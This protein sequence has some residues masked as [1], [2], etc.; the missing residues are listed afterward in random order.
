MEVVVQPTARQSHPSEVTHY[1]FG[2]FKTIMVTSNW[3]SV[4]ITHLDHLTLNIYHYQDIDKNI[5]K[6]LWCQQLLEIYIKKRH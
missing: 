6:V 5:Q 1:C 2:L 3:I 4:S